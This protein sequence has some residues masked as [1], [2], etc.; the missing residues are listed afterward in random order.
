MRKIVYIVLGTLAMIL[1]IIGIVLPLLP[2][3][4]ML[5]LTAY[6]Y[7]KGSKRFHEWFIATWLYK[8][9]LKNYAETR[10]M[11]KKGKIKLMLLVDVMLLIPFITIPIVPIRILIVVL[12]ITKYLYF[13]TQVGTIPQQ[14][15]NVG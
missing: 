12:V 9:Y 8:R 3:T 6:F 1:G 7:S 2:T 11:T 4:P 14:K 10:A 5:L 15:Q 13:Y